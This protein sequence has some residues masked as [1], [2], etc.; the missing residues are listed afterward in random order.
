[1]ALLMLTVYGDRFEIVWGPSE[2][3]LP[4]YTRTHSGTTGS[5]WRCD[6]SLIDGSKHTAGR[7]KEL[8]YIRAVAP[9]GALFLEDDLTT[10]ECMRGLAEEHECASGVPLA[11]NVAARKGLFVV[12][13][14][15]QSHMKGAADAMCAAEFANSTYAA[16]HHAMN[17]S[18][19]HRAWQ[20]AVLRDRARRQLSAEKK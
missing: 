5:E 1:M 14:C 16:R 12:R 2:W 19:V 20:A 17:F 6:F 9:V 15:A 8:A 3:T 11:S 13:E 10:P 18:D 4:T 7:Y